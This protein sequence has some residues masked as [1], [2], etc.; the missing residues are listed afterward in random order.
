LNDILSFIKE[1]NP[2]CVQVVNTDNQNIK[3]ED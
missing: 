2:G 3:T 1:K